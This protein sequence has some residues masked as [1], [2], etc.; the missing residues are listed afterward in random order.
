M[1]GPVVSQVH[2]YCASGGIAVGRLDQVE[3]LADELAMLA[4]ADVLVVG[5]ADIGVRVV[6]HENRFDRAQVVCSL[7]LARFAALRGGSRTS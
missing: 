4:E 3:R 1:S 7:M 6:A 5:E 2:L